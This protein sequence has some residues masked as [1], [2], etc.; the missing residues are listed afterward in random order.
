[1]KK[2]T[3]RAK[4][5]HCAALSF[6]R[7]GAV[8]HSRFSD[9]SPHLTLLLYYF[10]HFTTPTLSWHNYARLNYIHDRDDTAIPLFEGI[11]STF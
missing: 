8:L 2:E 11:Q 5:Y 7:F 10:P 3:D 1:M 9:L 4:N 6:N